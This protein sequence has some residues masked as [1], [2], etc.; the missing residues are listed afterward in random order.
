MYLLDTDHMSILE[1]GGT[2]ALTLT[3]KLSALSDSEVATTI[4]SY[5]EQCKGWL[6]KTAREKD[7]PLLRA[8]VQLGQHLE[9]YAGMTVFPYD[10]DAHRF[11]QELQSQKIRIGTQDLKIAAITLANDATL[12]TR[13]TRDFSRV[14]NLKFEDWTV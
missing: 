14:P 1:R 11:F 3:L 8:Y 10:A 9:I 2:A 6:A 7:E 4:V 5:E 13:N 12:L